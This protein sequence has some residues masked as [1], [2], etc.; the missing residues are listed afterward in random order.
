M[1]TGGDRAGSASG[2]GRP[3]SV[4]DDMLANSDSDDDEPGSRRAPQSE[5]G[6][7]YYLYLTISCAWDRLTLLSTACFQMML[8]CAEPQRALMAK[9]R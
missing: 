7:A 3:G 9:L 4:S 8:L 2:S 6:A 1:D 5:G